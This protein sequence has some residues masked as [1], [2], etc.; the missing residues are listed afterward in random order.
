MVFPSLESLNP[1]ILQVVPTSLG[2]GKERNIPKLTQ[3]TQPHVKQSKLCNSKY[4]INN[5]S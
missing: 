4:E 2:W 1:S 3:F 5:V